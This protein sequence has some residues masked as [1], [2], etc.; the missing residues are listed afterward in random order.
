MKR[1]FFPLVFAL[2]LLVTATALGS[3]YYLLGPKWKKT[4]HGQLVVCIDTSDV[5]E[6][7]VLSA[8]A[9]A[10][11][12]WSASPYVDLVPG[13]CSAKQGTAAVYVHVHDG[14]CNPSTFSCA[15]YIERRGYFVTANVIINT[16]TLTQGQHILN[17]VGCHEIGHTLGLDHQPSVA[18]CMYATAGASSSEVPNALD[19]EELGVLY[20]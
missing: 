19:Y 11:D 9:K 4:G 13:P 20:G 12:S 18:S 10:R 16:W 3:T 15:P 17:V 2:A 7:G 14:T 1:L 6:T 5:T 8:V